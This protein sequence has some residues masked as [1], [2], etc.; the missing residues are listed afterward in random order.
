MMA[1]RSPIFGAGFIISRALARFPVARRIP[2]KKLLLVV[3]SLLIA[4]AVTASAQNK[5]S[6][7]N[8]ATAN[9]NKSRNRGPIFR[10]NAGQVKQAQAILKQRGLYSGEQT[11]K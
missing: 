3:L 6:N 1:P 4:F 10:A 2:M 8:G 5:N 7:A 11:G 9:S